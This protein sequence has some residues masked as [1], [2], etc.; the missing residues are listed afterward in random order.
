MEKW[1]NVTSL[2]P[3]FDLPT[4]HCLYYK[5]LI[6]NMIMN[7]IIYLGTANSGVESA[8][9]SADLKTNV[10]ALASG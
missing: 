6:N 1:G 10:D 4:F 3:I 8:I 2:I 9:S 7:Y 5:F